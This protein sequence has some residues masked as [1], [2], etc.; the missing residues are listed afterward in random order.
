MGGYKV[1]N[2]DGT[3]PST[4]KEFTQGSLTN[5]SSSSH[6]LPDILEEILLE[7][8]N[9]LKATTIPLPQKLLALKTLT[10]SYK[11]IVTGRI[12]EFQ[13]RQITE[14]LPPKQLEFQLVVRDADGT[15]ILAPPKE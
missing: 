6:P 15:P 12:Q 14:D 5:K 10:S 2:Y 3:S 13:Y 1:V 7:T 11:D 4:I 8:A 9:E